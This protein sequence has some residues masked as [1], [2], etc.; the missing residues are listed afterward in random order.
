[1]FKVLRNGLLRYIL[2]TC[3]NLWC[4]SLF[5]V[6]RNGLLRYILHTC[7]NLWCN[8][9]SNCY[10]MDCFGT[11]FK[12]VQSCNV[13]ISLVRHISRYSSISLVNNITILYS[14]SFCARSWC[15][16]CI[17][18][19]KKR[20][21]RID[22]KVPHHPPPPGMLGIVDTHIPPPARSIYLCSHPI[23]S[24]LSPT[25]LANFKA[26]P[27]RKMQSSVLSFRVTDLF[28]GKFLLHPGKL[29]WNLK[30]TCLKRKIIFKT[31]HFWVP[32]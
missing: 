8:S 22:P 26:S 11:C 1:M 4:N 32:C 23:E 13:I 30:I 24:V 17:L 3:P 10:G 18:W 25:C 5:K 27:P 6:L 16:I 29:T 14:P 21:R 28:S 15:F 19:W 12:I 31:S 7:P 9:C 2:H 20:P